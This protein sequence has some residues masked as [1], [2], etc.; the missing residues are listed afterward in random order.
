V[1]FARGLVVWAEGNDVHAYRLKDRKRLSWPDAGGE[2]DAIVGATAYEVFIVEW[3]DDPLDPR[4]QDADTELYRA[5]W[6]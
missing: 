5:R 3:L 2:S 4:I 6:R 1:Q